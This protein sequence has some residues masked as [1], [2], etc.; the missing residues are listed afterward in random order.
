MV[1]EIIIGRKPE[2]VERFGTKATI[3]FGKNYVTMGKTTSLANPIM[4]DVARPH[5]IMI[6]GKRGTGKSYSLGVI[7][8]GMASLPE[9]IARNLSA[10]VFDTMGIYWTTKYPNLRD[11]ELLHS[12]EMK[13]EG[14]ESNTIVFV[15]SGHYKAMKRK[16]IPVD[17]AF[18]IGAADLSGTDWCVTL[19]I[20]VTDP[21]GILICRVVGALRKEKKE[22]GIDE[23]IAAINADEKSDRATKEAGMNRFEAIKEW[24]LFEKKRTPIEKIVQRGKMSVLDLSC[25]TYIMGGFSIRA[26]VIGL[27]CKRLL[28]ERMTARR[29]EELAEIQLGY[30]YF[31]ERYEK[32]AE[33]QVPLVWLFIDEAHEFLPYE[34]WN[35]ATGPLI[36]IIREGRQPGI[37][38]VLATQ[39][40]GK[41]HSDVVTQ[42][43]LVIS[44]RVTARLDIQALNNIMQ[45]YLPHALEKYLGE[46]PRRKG[47]AIVLDDNQERVY[48]IQVRPRITWHGGAEPSAIPP[49]RKEIVP[50]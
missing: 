5:V 48:P 30:S 7:C 22:Y 27:L 16:G 43:D 40:P 12:W 37:S 17:E 18:S 35:F 19:G 10:L 8:E 4:L 9:E 47:S 32:K 28:E 6:C 31:R 33:K 23:I 26:L 1:Y 29:Y 2:D 42:C 44:H 15:P 39:Q 11:E 21:L 49:K 34:G 25:Y 24:G 50:T 13:P 41:I 46:L 36:Q 38:L 14:F 3:F 45:T 20:E